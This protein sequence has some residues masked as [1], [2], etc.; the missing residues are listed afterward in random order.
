MSLKPCE[1]PVTHA[2]QH[3]RYPSGRCV[4]CG[5]APEEGCRV[6]GPTVEHPERPY[7]KDDQSC[8]D[9]SCGN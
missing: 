6:G 4:T 5:A 7:C 9:F 8:C 1:L 2:H 3:P